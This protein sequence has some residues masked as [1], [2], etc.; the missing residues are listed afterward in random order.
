MAGLWPGVLPTCSSSRACQTGQQW[1]VIYSIF[2]PMGL[3]CLTDWTAVTVSPWAFGS[4][5]ISNNLQIME[6]RTLFSTVILLPLHPLS[7]HIVSETAFDEQ[8]LR[9]RM[10]ANTNLCLY[11]QLIALG[12][13]PG[14]SKGCVLLD[15]FLFVPCWFLFCFLFVLL[16]R[17]LH[18]YLAV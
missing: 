11:P 5:S 1:M 17:T 10:S 12:L 3:L 2:M 14:A 18:W 7:V 8:R 6:Q 16:V 9:I 15:C 4:A 13:K